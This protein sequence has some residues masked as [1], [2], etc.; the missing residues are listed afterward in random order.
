MNTSK[1]NNTEQAIMRAAEE[2]F[3]QNGF[4]ATS[5]VDIAR[6]VG[7]NQALV[8]Y[9]FRTKENL[10]QQIFMKNFENFLSFATNYSFDVDFTTLL[11]QIIENYFKLLTNNRKLP[12]FLINEFL[13]NEDRRLFVR[14]NV[15]HNERRSALYYRFDKLVQDEVGKGKIRPISTLDLL[16]NIVS[17]AV[18]TFV[19][20]PMY[21]DWLEKDENEVE[22]YIEQ[23]KNEIITLILN[24]LKK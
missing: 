1:E 11:R 20:L 5:T 8:H 24:G 22:D 21:I 6:K 9:Y 16:L 7:C 12:F 17:L 14:E 3:F 23:R 18:F 13:L 10:F 15:V 2:L 4:E 19:S